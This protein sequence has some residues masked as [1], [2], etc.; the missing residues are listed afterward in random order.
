MPEPIKVKWR[1]LNSLLSLFNLDEKEPKKLILNIFILALVAIILTVFTIWYSHQPKWCSYI[2]SG[3]VVTKRCFIT[4]EE[5]KAY[6]W[7]A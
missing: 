2:E 3:G 6:L 1:G 7:D 4:A 5:Y